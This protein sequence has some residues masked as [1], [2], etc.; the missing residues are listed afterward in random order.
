MAKA[1]RG[2]VTIQKRKAI[3]IER[4]KPVKKPSKKAEGAKAITRSHFALLKHRGNPIIRPSQKNQWESW[5]TFNPAAL[6]EDGKVH[7]VYRA[8]GSDGISR[9]GYAASSDGISLDERH[10]KPIFELID[11][12]ISESA[13]SAYFSGGSWG[14]AEDP[15]ITKLDDKVHMLFVAFNGLP[16]LALV[17]IKWED[18]LNKRWK[19]G[20]VKIISPPGLIDKSGCLFPERI[21]GK[22]AILHRIFPN[23]LLDFVDDLD[24]PEGTYLSGDKEVWGKNSIKVRKGQW[25]SLKIGPGAPPIKT[26]HGWLLIYYGVDEKDRRYKIGAMLLD[27]KN[28]RKVLART[29]KPVLEPVEWYEN[30]GHKHGVAYPCGAVVVG[31]NLYVYYGGADSYV[32]VAS[33]DLKKFLDDLIKSENPKL[34]RVPA[35]RHAKS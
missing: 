27:L 28:P 23:I 12:V 6:F 1:I 18:F 33:A 35:K 22:Y 26:D 3:K 21:N 7:L 11:P 19:W 25:D 9:L 34:A 13:E 14:G 16:R 4:R 31:K 20:G 15:R 29:K 8:I 32:C 2:K 24:F 17:S 30:V 5:Q 10:E